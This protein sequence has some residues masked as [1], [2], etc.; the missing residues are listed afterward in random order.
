MRRYLVIALILSTLL[1]G[2]AI[3]QTFTEFPREGM[4]KEQVRAMWGHPFYVSSERY[5][6]TLYEIW[7]YRRS[8]T[9]VKPAFG[10]GR[11]SSTRRYDYATVRFRDGVVVGI[12]R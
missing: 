3:G 11:P 9:V 10:S 5:G 6:D 12:S 2:C 4:T 1:P 7:T 8:Q